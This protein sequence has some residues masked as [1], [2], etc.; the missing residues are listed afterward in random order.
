MVC[1]AC[2]ARDVEKGC[3]WIGDF[4]M[5]YPN[6]IG[7]TVNGIPCNPP[8]HLCYAYPVGFAYPL[9]GFFGGNTTETASYPPLWTGKL[10]INGV[11]FDL[12]NSADFG[13]NRDGLGI[14]T[15]QQYG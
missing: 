12:E 8:D 7:S 4:L 6:C 10:K 11:E 15:P 3:G 2:C 14:I 5:L 9:L 1:R 13:V